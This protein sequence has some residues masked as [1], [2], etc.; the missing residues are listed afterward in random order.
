M[1]T[2]LHCLGMNEVSCDPLLVSFR[3]HPLPVHP[4]VLYTVQLYTVRTLLLF[5]RFIGGWRTSEE[6]SALGKEDGS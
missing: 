5:S 3:L 4:S 2:R 1:V 6:R